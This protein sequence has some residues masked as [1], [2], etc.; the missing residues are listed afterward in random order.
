MLE[1]GAGDGA[2]AAALDGGRVRRR[3]RST[4]RAAATACWPVAL[5]QLEAEAGSFDAAVAIV[6]LHHVQPLARSCKRLAEVLKP[7]APLI[8]D[9]FDV[10][11]LDERAAEW[12]LTQRRAIGSPREETAGRA[13]GGDARPHP[14]G[15]PRSP[16]SSRRG[17]TWARPCPAPYLYRRHLDWALRPVEEGLI[18]AGALPA[19]GVRFV[20]VRR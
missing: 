5:H 15:L 9:E 7:G 17:S 4:R 12:W 14:P 1:V 10:E 2:L 18:A 19:T 8:V 6:S 11:R 20:A 16:R 3:R 13:R